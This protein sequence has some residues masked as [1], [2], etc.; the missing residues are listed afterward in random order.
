MERTIRRYYPE[1]VLYSVSLAVLIVTL[2]TIQEQGVD[3]LVLWSA[4]KAVFSN[5]NPYEMELRFYT[6]AWSLLLLAPLSLLPFSAVCFLWSGFSLAVWILVLRRLEI[7]PIE[8]TLFLLNPFFVYGM[9]LGSY[10]WLALFGLLM[11][12]TFEAWF[13]LLKPQTLIGYI[14]WRIKALGISSKLFAYALPI[15]VL[16]FTMAIG[17]YRPVKLS[18]MTWNTSF[19]L[20]GIPIGLFL[21]WQSFRRNDLLYA[22]AASPFLSPYVSIGTWAIPFLLLT[23]KRWMMVIGIILGWILVLR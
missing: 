22:L 16:F 12:P 3:L 17:L 21:I 14:V 23:K 1:I 4:G 13:L 18:E 5:V 8:S 19:G 11:P 10:D 7:G 15:V 9:I 6:P 20:I 2:N